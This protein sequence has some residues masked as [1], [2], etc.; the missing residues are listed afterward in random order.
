MDRRY[1]G[2]AYNDVLCLGCGDYFEKRALNTF[3][4]QL[5]P[6]VLLSILSSTLRHKRCYTAEEKRRMKERI[7]CFVSSSEASEVTK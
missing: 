2:Q 1:I 4:G 3:I 5:L 6:I 7:V